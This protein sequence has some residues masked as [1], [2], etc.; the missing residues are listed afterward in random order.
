LS[1]WNH[2][3]WLVLAS[4]SATR[5]Q[6]LRGAGLPYE[7][8]APEIEE[9]AI[10]AAHPGVPPDELARALAEA[11]ALAVSRATPDALVIGADQVLSL[12]EII[13]HK[14][15][16]QPEALQT[17]MRLSGQTH[18]L[19]SAFAIARNGAVLAAETDAAEMTMR[20][21]DEAALRLYLDA[22]GPSVLGS[23]GV[24]H[25]ESFGVHLF[26]RVH[27]DHATVL[28]LPMLKL[29][30]ALRALGALRL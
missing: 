28:G 21:L 1:I 22:A 30:A 10:E 11:K 12:G 26:S 14:S 6:L 17:L 13:F 7:T 3:F 24:Y 2:A 4:Q 15:K 8:A 19:T 9:R 25:W 16:S 20:R 18:R 5:G 27:G 23:V 29:L